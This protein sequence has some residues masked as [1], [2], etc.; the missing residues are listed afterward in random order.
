MRGPFLFIW[1]SRDEGLIW[2]RLLTGIHSVCME[3]FH[4]IYGHWTR[5][6]C[7]HAHKRFRTKVHFVVSVIGIHIYEDELNNSLCIEDLMWSDPDDIEN[8]AVSPRGAGWLFGGNITREVRIY[9]KL[10]S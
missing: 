7:F 5:S 2:R 8:W 4:L 1:S 6:G 3:A 9:R 10:H